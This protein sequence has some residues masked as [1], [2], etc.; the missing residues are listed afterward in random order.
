VQYP[1]GYRL[2]RIPD[3]RP[4]IRQAI[5]GIWPDTGY[6]KAGLSGRI[7]G[8][9][10]IQCIPTGDNELFKIFHGYVLMWTTVQVGSVITCLVPAAVLPAG[11]EHCK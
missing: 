11:R 10:D 5:S 3:I 7:S 4:D 8:Q 9:P 6:K 1:A 2:G